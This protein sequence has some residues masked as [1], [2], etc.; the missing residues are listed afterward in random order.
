MNRP[1]VSLEGASTRRKFLASAAATA[2][3]LAFPALLT[4]CATGRKAG[5]PAAKGGR[6]AV[7]AFC[8]DFNWGD[9]GAS[10]PGLYAQ[11]DPAE[12]VRWYQDLGANVIQTFCVSY[13]GYAW[14]PSQVAPVT[15]GLRHRN[16]LG[17]MVKLGHRAG[18]KVMGYYTLGANPYWEAR[19]P[20]L[21]HHE[22]SDYIKIPFTLEYLDYFCSSVRDTLKKVPIDGF[23]V[24]WVRPTQH[25]NWLPCEKAMYRQLMGE[26]FPSAGAPAVD[27]TLEFDRRA[28]ARA[29][30]HLKSTVHSTRRVIIWTNHPFVEA[31]KPLWNNHPLLQQVDWVLN[32]SPEPEWLDWLRPQVG[33]QTLIVQNLCGWEGHDANL[34][35]KIDNRVFGLYGFAK[36][37]AQTTLPTDKVPANIKNI[38]LLREA[39]HSL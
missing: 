13:N 36:A 31:E 26:G 11:A 37:D 34:W 20:E 28:I 21:V 16:F 18:M 23:M 27:V 6:K 3:A 30:D 39:Y 14:Y 7:K 22:D 10:E 9:H 19:N 5:K 1:F 24:D 12:H 38:N 25:K 33:P 15:P 32:E 2:S 17:D 4:G 8:I 35:R 29:W